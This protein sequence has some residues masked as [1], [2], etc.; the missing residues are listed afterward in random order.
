M[1]IWIFCC[2]PARWADLSG[3]TGRAYSML[4][5]ALDITPLLDFVP[6]SNL[7]NELVVIR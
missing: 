2:A 5:C 6:Q 7:Q 4:V 3:L 1:L